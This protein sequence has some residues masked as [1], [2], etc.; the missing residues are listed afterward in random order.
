MSEY[1]LTRHRGKYSV[2][3][4]TSD[5]QRKRITTGTDDKRLAESIGREI[6]E[7][8]NAA[9]S[10]RI[11]DLW[12]LYVKDRG[13]DG[14]QT[15]RFKHIWTALAPHFAN[16]IG[17]QVTREDCRGY[18]KDR[19]EQGKSASTVATELSLLRACLRWRYGN[20]APAVWVP[21]PS[22]P[23]SDWLTK[24]QVRTILD[25]TETPHIQLFI[26]IAV[27][28]GARAGAILDL[29]WDRV[30]FDQG[31]IN[32]K[33]AGR[34]QT[35]KRRVVVPMNARARTALKQAHEARLTDNVIE[36]AGKPLGSVKKGLQ[37]LSEKV[38]V[39]FSAHVFRHT[40]AVWMAQADV[41]MA[42]IAQYLGHTKTT[43]TE[44]YYARYSPSYM[45]DASEATEF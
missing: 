25:A 34:A 21:P 44:A 23:R 2:T 45:R 32:F 30:D 37:R 24:E 6:W 40:A 27:T 43:V 14:V 35:N 10:E 28:T 8:R 29:T 15:E 31:T 20:Q 39:K 1:S 13:K 41:P 4:R 9:A 22:A 5:G 12:P 33:P 19:T 3:F 18:H 11:A 42:K 16:R 17:N 36:Y 38:G 26:T 7:R